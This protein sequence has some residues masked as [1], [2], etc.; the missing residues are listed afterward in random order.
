[1]K[2]LLPL[3]PVG[4][5]LISDIL[6]VYEKEGIVQYIVNGLPV[7]SHSNKDLNAFRYITSNFI[8]QGLCRKIDVQR[9]FHL[10]EDSVQRAYNKFTKEGVDAFFSEDG[11]KG[12]A[13]KIMQSIDNSLEHLP[14]ITQKQVVLFEKIEQHQQKEDELKM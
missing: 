1:M 5:K 7:Y 4:T 13:Y 12:K 2:L 3:F 10:S 8:H 11:R 9:C 6:G 14:A